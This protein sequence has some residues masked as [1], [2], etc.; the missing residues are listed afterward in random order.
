MAVSLKTLVEAAPLEV[1]V[2][3]QIIERLETL[4]DD[5]KLRISLACWQALAWQFKA[6]YKA[7][8]DQALLE[9]REG[10]RQYNKEDFQKI[11]NDLYQEFAKLLKSAQTEEEIAYVREEIKKYINQP[12]NPPQ[13]NPSSKQ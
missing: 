12:P 5:Q 1:G 13:N 3:N 2:K 9:I 11:E 8:V 6:R 4:T 7:Q 10:K